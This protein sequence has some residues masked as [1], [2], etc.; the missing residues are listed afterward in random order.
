MKRVAVLAVALLAL[1]PLAGRAEHADID[2]R[3]MTLNPDG[4]GAAAEEHASSDQEPPAGG[5]NARP[6]FKC[7]VNEPLVLQFFLTNTYPHG[8]LKDATVRYFVVREAKVRQKTVPDLRDGAVVQGSFTLNLKPK[9][10]VGAR[11][12]FALREPG[13]YLLRVQ[14]A[15]T[16]SDHE[17]FSAIDLKAD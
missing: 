16:R 1:A 6:L 9:G 8:E 4:G 12:R 3:V 7:K 13:V 15:N 2:L 10:R 17:H 14:T 11:L 5:V